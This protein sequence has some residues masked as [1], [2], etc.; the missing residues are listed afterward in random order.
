MPKLVSYINVEL[1]K[2]NE[3]YYSLLKK[4]RKKSKTAMNVII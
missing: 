3:Y 1:Y 4:S 2:K